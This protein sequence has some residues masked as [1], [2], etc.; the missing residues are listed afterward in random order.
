MAATSARASGF[1]V[2]K[3]LEGVGFS[4]IVVI[5]NKVLELR[6][7]GQAV[8]AFHGGEPFFETPEVVKQA[9]F[10]AAEENKTRYAP[11][12]GIAPLRTALV[13]KLRQRNAIDVTADQVLITVG[14]AHALYCA[15][16]AVL[17]PA[18]N[19]CFFRLTG[20]PSPT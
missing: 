17:D 18:R 13:Q 2:A 11:S 12:S 5:R 19:A 3:R 7:A 1:R 4:D 9:L 6:A 20:H 8:H 14:G 15:F 16:Q 10:T